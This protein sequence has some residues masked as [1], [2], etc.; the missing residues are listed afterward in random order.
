M[1][2]NGSLG[3]SYFIPTKTPAEWNS[4]VSADAS[5]SDISVGECYL[6]NNSHT[7]AQC[8]SLGGTVVDDGVGNLMCKYAAVSCPSG[9]TQYGNWSTTV[10]GLSPY[11]NEGCTFSGTNSQFSYCT[12]ATASCV[13]SFHPWNNV[14][15]ETQS[16]SGMQDYMNRT[17]DQ[18]SPGQCGFYSDIN[19]YSWGCLGATNTSV[20]APRTEV[21]CY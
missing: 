6:V 14:S 2:N 17:Y 20:S 12:Q 4:F 3:R 8:A 7:E 10:A 9:W 21:G 1:T 11:I 19:S 18:N 13:T 5:L 15:P 16:C